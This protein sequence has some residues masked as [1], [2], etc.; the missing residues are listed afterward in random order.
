MRYISAFFVI[1]RLL[2]Y[3]KFLT[4]FVHIDYNDDK[5]FKKDG[6]MYKLGLVTMMA[7][8][9]LLTGCA[10]NEQRDNYQEAS[11]ELCNTDV[12]IYSVSD[13]GQVRIVCA[14]Q[15]KFSLA[16]ES[17]LETMRDINVNYCSGEGLGQ[18]NE[19]RKYYMFKC[20]SGTL[21][22]ISK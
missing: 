20:K 4:L 22:S 13:D 9:A 11:F 2:L 21:I 3:Q 6:V 7:V 19:T 14:D 18:F 1:K 16:S 15:S 12:K 10:S 17:T 5:Q 8:S